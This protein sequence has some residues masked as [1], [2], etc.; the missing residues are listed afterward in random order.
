V[1]RLRNAAVLKRI[2]A[3][4]GNFARGISPSRKVLSGIEVAPFK[5]NAAAAACI[6]A[7]FEMGWGWRPWELEAANSMGDKERHNVP[8]ILSLLEEYSIPITWATVGHLFL[9]SCARS[10]AGL[11]HPEMPRPLTD[12]T[13]SGDWYSHD[14]CS[15]VRSA[16]SWYAPDLIQQIIECKIPQEVGTH[17]F[18]HTDCTAACSSPEVVRRELES[19][20]D[21]MAPFGQR[22]RSL[23]FP[24]NRAEYS[25]LPL[26]ASAGIAVVRHRDRETG[27]RLSYPERTAEGV[28]KIYESMNLRIA[29]RYEYLQRAK[30]FIRKAMERHAVYSLWFHPSDPTEWFESQ[31]REILHYI[32]AERR[33]GRLWVATMRDLAAYCEAREQ[34]QLTVE[35]VG[36][37]LTLSFRT[38]LDISRFGTPE[39]SLLITATCRPWLAWVELVSG[40]MKPVGV[41]PASGDG[42]PRW[43][44]NVPATARSL[45][46][47]FEGSSAS[48]QQPGASC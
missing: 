9:E 39:I 26:L 18:S 5:D 38:S 4:Q 35:R 6:S 13:W 19:C 11:A 8:L 32:D 22:P 29:R 14:P 25:N 10:S 27:I 28:Y 34:L 45:R 12:G 33:S 41:R 21:A 42:P 7:D 23:V 24:R 30:I 46:L 2:F 44:V 17:T 3:A 16:P 20:I 1:M 31:L 36:D 48:L 47:S 40:E 37:S 15:N 43:L